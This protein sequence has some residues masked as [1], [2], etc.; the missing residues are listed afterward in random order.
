MGVS[1]AGAIA[2]TGA[3]DTGVAIPMADST[4]AADANALIMIFVAPFSIVE[5]D[6]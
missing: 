1:T 3:A 4:T 5:R 2:E 6:P